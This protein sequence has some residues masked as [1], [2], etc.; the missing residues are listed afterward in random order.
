MT[1]VLLIVSGATVAH[2]RGSAA[3]VRDRIAVARAGAGIELIKPG[4]RRVAVLTRH[5]GWED[6]DP[7]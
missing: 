1:G 6:T 7:A 2:D 5:R 4:A 3:A